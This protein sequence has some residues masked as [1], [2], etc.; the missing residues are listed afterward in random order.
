MISFL[1]KIRD[2]LNE[3]IKKHSKFMCDKCGNGNYLRVAKEVL[4]ECKCSAW[5]PGHKCPN[6]IEDKREPICY[7]VT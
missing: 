4:Y 3:Y 2:F 6:F 7:T 5:K 1:I